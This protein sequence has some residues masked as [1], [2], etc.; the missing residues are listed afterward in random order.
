MHVEIYF[1]MLIFFIFLNLSFF[2]IWRKTR[3]RNC[4][5]YFLGKKVGVIRRILQHIELL[6]LKKFFY[7]LNLMHVIY[8]VVK[9]QQINYFKMYSYSTVFCKMIIDL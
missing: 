7:E 6:V 8:P 4:Q 2:Y 9:I 5:S 1:F 3:T